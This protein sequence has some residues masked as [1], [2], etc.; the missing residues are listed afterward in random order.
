LSNI[1]FSTSLSA[2]CYCVICPPWRHAS[3]FSFKDASVDS[4]AHI[5]ARSA[6]CF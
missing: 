6:R 4:V 2:L 1:G 5:G 3:V